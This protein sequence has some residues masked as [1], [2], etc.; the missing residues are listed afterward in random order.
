[1][2]AAATGGPYS[3]AMTPSYT[4]R[5]RVIA[6]VEAITY[7]ILL[8]LTIVK[9]LDGPNLVP[10]MGPIHG[11]AFL[12]YLVLTLLV[13]EEQRWTGWQT[14]LVIVAAALPFGAFVVN[15]RMVSDPAPAA[16]R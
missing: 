15:S 10:V 12:V 16:D 2:A 14:V 4:A 8:V 13:R 9:S 6:L 1:M 3:P 5:F 11:I 7:L